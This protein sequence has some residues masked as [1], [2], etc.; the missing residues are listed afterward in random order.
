MGLVSAPQTARRGHPPDFVT[1]LVRG[2]PHRWRDR[3]PAVEPSSKHAYRRFG[4]TCVWSLVTGA[5]AVHGDDDGRGLCAADFVREAG[6]GALKLEPLRGAP[7]PPGFALWRAAGGSVRQA[8][9]VGRSSDRTRHYRT[10]R[11]HRS[12]YRSNAAPSSWPGQRAPEG[13]CGGRASAGAGTSGSALP[14]H[15]ADA[16]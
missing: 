15:D 12:A 4:R 6:L 5:P 10:L 2:H 1:G 9:C 14:A 7:A 16:V 8:R 11:V 13:P 3:N